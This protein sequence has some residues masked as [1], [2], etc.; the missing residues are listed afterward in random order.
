M[1]VFRSMSADPF[2]GVQFVESIH[3]T[4]IPGGVPR[5]DDMRAMVDHFH[6]LG[7]IRRK[8]AAFST[9]NGRVMVI[10]PDLLKAMRDRLSR[11]I[12]SRDQN[13]FLYGL[14]GGF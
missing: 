10:H 3:A 1:D 6:R 13:A 5:T 12:D 4:A 11:E 9:H 2:A 7:L 14:K 8:P